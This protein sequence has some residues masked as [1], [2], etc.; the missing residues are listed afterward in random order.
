MPFRA[1]PVPTSD[2]VTWYVDR[3]PPSRAGGPR[4]TAPDRA[5]RLQWALGFVAYEAAVALDPG[6]AVRRVPADG[7]PLVWFGLTDKPV[8]GRP[9]DAT[10]CDTG[11]T[12]SGYPA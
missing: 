9:L 3:R 1:L 6:L 2:P 10:D 4:P 12:A 7:L 8:P 11:Y 5:A